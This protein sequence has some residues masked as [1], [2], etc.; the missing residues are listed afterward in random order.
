MSEHKLGILGIS[1]M[2]VGTIMG[3]GFA[4]GREIWQ[5]FGVFG[6]QGYIGVALVA[7]LFVTIGLMTAKIA[8]MLN[9]NEMGRVI[10]PGGNQKLIG[11]VSKFMALILFTV[12][13]TM[14]AAGGA[15]FN[16]Q[17]GQS[18]ILGGVVIILLVILTVI[19]GFERVSKV[20]RFIMPVLA[21][22]VIGVS[23]MVIFGDL[24][25]SG[26]EAE[27]TPSPL[28]QTWF[29]AAPLYLSY[30]ILGVI[31]IVST[32]SIN[33]KSDRQA[34][35]GASLG[36]ILLG[37]LA[38]LL[39]AA[40]MTDMT[41]SQTMD[42]PMLAF[43]ARISKGANIV[44][45][46]VLFLAIYASA[47]SNYYAFTTVLRPS[48]FKRLKIIII[49]WIGFAFGLVGFTNVVSYMFPI[50]GFLGFSIIA[51]LVA[52]FYDVCIKKNQGKRRQMTEGYDIIET[53][54]K[55]VL[56]ETFE[57]HDRFAMPE[58]IVRVTAGH[59]GEAFLIFGS[60]KTVLFDCGMAYCGEKTVK[61]IKAALALHNASYQD[62]TGV[63]GD[64]TIDYVILSHTHYD[65][66]GALPNIRQQWPDA[67]IFGAAHAKAVFEK[68][69]AIKM[70]KQ[71]GEEAS[72]QYSDGNDEILTKGLAVDQI[73]SDG[74]E[75]PLGIEKI[76]V[77]E[78]RGHTNCSLTFVLEPASIMF[79]SESTG[80]LAKSDLMHVAILKSY[81]D[82][83]ASLEKCRNYNPKHIISPH[84]GI[85]PEF[86]K[87]RYWSLFL[88]CAEAKKEFI[89]NLHQRGF[90]SE[91]ILER[92]IDHNWLD[93]QANEQPKAAFT[94]NT[95]NMIKVVLKEFE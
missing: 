79:T 90:S 78:T 89:C 38:F 85:V 58:G 31:P 44:Y 7:L 41:F 56:F 18:R 33:A 37:I 10:V 77:L 82:S 3:A 8:R 70:M 81:S 65:H 42:M 19:G 20:F 12:I 75:I 23:L 59:G 50:E 92:Y 40:M 54:N 57:N 1:F 26:V 39:A 73:I 27:I 46:C 35:L 87:D 15:L 83:I 25:A 71:L 34:L 84:F 24:K 45:T 28:A 66:V 53:P 68:P 94:I 32:A 47:T 14:S 91:E 13:I 17:L 21:T 2:Y 62:K 30:N 11:F 60:E 72:V 43:S 93:K 80:V 55:G 49:A 64:R 36:G 69:G 9:T 61:N 74:D 51:M 48:R 16:Q 22:V 86:F 29:L 5:F 67:I 88:E 6:R 4:S 52:N 76:I 63:I 95:V